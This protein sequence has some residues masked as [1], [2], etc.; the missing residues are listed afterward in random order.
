MNYELPAGSKQDFE[1]SGREIQTNNDAKP[2]Q[3]EAGF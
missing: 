2:V 3:V 1:Q